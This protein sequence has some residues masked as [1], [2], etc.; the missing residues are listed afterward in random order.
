M[1]H[2]TDVHLDKDEAQIIDVYNHDKGLTDGSKDAL[3]MTS[4][5]RSLTMSSENTSTPLE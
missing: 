1:R 4:D 5:Q 2:D 3:E